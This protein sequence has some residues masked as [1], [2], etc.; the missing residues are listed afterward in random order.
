MR[1]EKA[2]L[3]IQTSSPKSFGRMYTLNMKSLI[4][5]GHLSA[6]IFRKLIYP[7]GLA[8]KLAPKRVE[9]KAK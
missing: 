2:T 5:Q 8:I 3:C 6:G 7:G 4:C 9:H 1:R